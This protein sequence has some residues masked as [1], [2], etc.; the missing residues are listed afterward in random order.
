[1]S[2][3]EAAADETVGRLLSNTP[4]QLLDEK[5]EVQYFIPGVPMGPREPGNSLL[6]FIDSGTTSRHPQLAGLVVE[7]KTFVDGPLHDEIG[8]GT[9]A[10]L[11]ALTPMHIPGLPANLPQ[12]GFLSAKVTRDGSDLRARNVIAAFDWLVSRGARVIN[13][14][15]GFDR[16]TPDVQKLCDHIRANPSVMVSAAAGNLGSDVKVYP[17]HC[18]APN[19]LAVGETKDNRPTDTS[20]R[21]DVYAEPPKFQARWSYLAD[22]GMARARAG[23]VDEAKEL[24]RQSLAAEEN[25]EALTQLALIH[26]REDRWADA[27]P[28]AE[29][30][31]GLAPDEPEVLQTLGAVLLALGDNDAAIARFEQGLAIAPNHLFALRNLARAWIA[32]GDLARALQAVERAIAMRPDDAV[33]HDL[34][35]SIRSGLGPAR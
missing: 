23:R 15:L 32:K 6:G 31:V 5:G 28:F 25:P 26:A 11:I 34:R 29:R 8:H 21:G 16:L 35:D 33:L 20:G 1:M 10:M 9:F 22:Q 4:L 18:G 24:F 2:T 19:V 7:E 17:A 14:S 13:M 27:R 12:F 3:P 30:A